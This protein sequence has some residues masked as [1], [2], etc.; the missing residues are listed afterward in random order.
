MQMA[1]YVSVT[2]MS[3]DK[4][5][6]GSRIDVESFEYRTRIPGPSKTTLNKIPCR[7]TQPPILNGTGFQLYSLRSAGCTRWMPVPGK[8]DWGDRMSASC[9]AGVCIRWLHTSEFCQYQFGLVEKNSVLWA[10][11]M[12]KCDSIGLKYFY[13]VERLSVNWHGAN[14]RV[15]FYSLLLLNV[16]VRCSNQI[17]SFIYD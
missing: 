10:R 14:G 1:G 2:L 11:R 7:P 13:V 12:R 5:L 16:W 8:A 6:N 17:K 15:L 4:Q 3:F 9:S